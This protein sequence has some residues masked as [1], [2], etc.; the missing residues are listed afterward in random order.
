MPFHFKDEKTSHC[1]HLSQGIG[2]SK[3][4][5]NTALLESSNS[6]IKQKHPPH[7]KDE[8]TEAQRLG[9]LPKVIK[10]GFELKLWS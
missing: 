8:E 3:G 9:K 7:S 2:S 1:Q 6:P 5:K 4:P 10:I